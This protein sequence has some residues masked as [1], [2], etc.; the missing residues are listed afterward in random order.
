MLHNNFPANFSANF[1]AFATS[2]C[3]RPPPPY[4]TTVPLMS[5]TLVKKVKPQRKRNVRRGAP[6]IVNPRRMRRQRPVLSAIGSVPEPAR[7]AP[8]LEYSEEAE[9]AAIESDDTPEPAEETVTDDAPRNDSS[10]RS[11]ASNFLATYFREMA[12]LEVLK[13]EEEFVAAQ[14]IEQ[15]ELNLWEQLLAYAPLVDHLV[16]LVD[17]NLG[18]LAGEFRT[19]RRVAAEVRKSATKVNQRK[20]QK[21]ARRLAELL[22]PLDNDKIYLEAIQAETAKIARG[23]VL[24]SGKRVRVSPGS[25]SFQRH[26]A[27]IR[28]ASQ[29]AER[30]RNDFVRA[31]LRLVVSIARRFNH[32][33]MPLADLIQEGNIGLMKAVE[34][35]DYRR[36]FRFS[37]YASWWI[38]HAISRALAD[39][40][41]QVRLPVHMIDAYHRISKATRELTAQLGRQP[42][43]EEIAKA[44]NIAAAKIEKMRCYL[45]DQSFSLDKPVNDEDGRNL[46]EYLHDPSAEESSPVENL[47]AEAMTSEMRRLLLDLKPIEADILRKRFGLEDD[48]E[49]TL[50]EIGQKYNLSRERI[51][52]LQE[53]ALCKMRRALARKDLV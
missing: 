23:M 38:R 50:K 3:N 12:E 43:S 40:G 11:E 36:G 28:G 7:E 42:T 46:V 32:G 16:S 24:R 20:L 4:P 13:P 47:A 45:V 41:R 30:A 22:R 29:A 19:L 49:L 1:L 39:K 48:K 33:R 34:R 15:L 21:Q 51:R 44:A 35:Y 9:V 25:Q 14:E 52:Q 37:T 26:L 17:D 53:Q 18:E 31:N 5:T 10:P 8:A 6:P 27:R 2:H